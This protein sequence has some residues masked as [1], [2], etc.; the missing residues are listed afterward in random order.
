MIAACG[1]RHEFVTRRA[2]R[3]EI[4][5]NARGFFDCEAVRQFPTEIEGEFGVVLTPK[6]ASPLAPIPVVVIEP[7]PPLIGARERHRRHLLGHK[8]VVAGGRLAGVEFVAENGG[9]TGMR[10][11]KPAPVAIPVEELNASNYE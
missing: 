9:G 6:R 7:Q 5:T 4:V 10:L 1:P 2:A 3:S 8:I 11:R